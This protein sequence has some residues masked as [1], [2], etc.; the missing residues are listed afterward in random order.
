MGNSTHYVFK[1][2]RISSRK[3]GETF[4]EL[5]TGNTNRH[6]V[7]TVEKKGYELEERNW[8]G[9][10]SAKSRAVSFVPFGT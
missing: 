10:L 7:D 4:L 2:A 9:I 5:C 1:Q 8:R 6:Y 3:E